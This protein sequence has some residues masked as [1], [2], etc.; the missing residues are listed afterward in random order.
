MSEMNNN[1]IMRD[2]S[3]EM[4]I[5][6]YLHYSWTDIVLSVLKSWVSDYIILLL[7]EELPSTLLQGRSIGDKFPLFWI[8]WWMIRQDISRMIETTMFFEAK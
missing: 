6:C 4:E 7:S 2:K 1:H 8:D 3:N 5:F